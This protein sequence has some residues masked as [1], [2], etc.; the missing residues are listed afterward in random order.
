MMVIVS[1]AIRFAIQPRS[2]QG[3]G[4]VRDRRLA[5]AQ[6][7]GVNMVAKAR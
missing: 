2:I 4:V 6:K 5:G 7:D 3:S 1:L